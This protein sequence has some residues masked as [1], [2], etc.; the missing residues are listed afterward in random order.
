MRR[1]AQV[2]TC[3]PQR[4]SSGCTTGSAWVNKVR[5]SEYLQAHGVAYFVI[6]E[7]GDSSHPSRW[8]LPCAK[9]PLNCITKAKKQYLLSSYLMGKGPAAGLFIS[10]VQVYGYF[11]A[12]TPECHAKVGVAVTEATMIALPKGNV[13]IRNFS[14][15]TVVLNPGTVPLDVPLRPGVTYTDLYG[16][17]VH[18]P[19]S[20]PG[21]NA[22]VLLHPN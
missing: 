12:C 14:S 17:A 6:N 8:R 21:E 13:W 7:V 22:T 15:A 3:V 5:W 20:V 9:D 4:C 18:P 2:Y 16:N 10:N 1:F 19:V 11:S